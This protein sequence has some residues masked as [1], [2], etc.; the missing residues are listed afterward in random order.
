[1]K[2]II[3]ILILLVVTVSIVAA[4]VPVPVKPQSKP[5]VLT[6]GVAHLGNGRVIENSIIAFDK[7][8]IT[9]VADANAGPVDISRYEEIKIS[10]KHVYPGFILPNS[11]LGLIEV[12]SVRAM[13]DYNERGQLNPN[14][15]ALVAY[16]TDSEM[17]A[18]MR[19]NGVLLAETVPTGGLISGTSSLMEMEGWD[20]E[21]AVHTA[22]IGIHLN[23]PGLTR[24]EFDFTTFTSRQVPNKEYENLV[25][26]LSRFFTDA[27]AYGKLATKDLNL[28]MES[29]QGL[30]NGTRSLFIHAEKPKEI[31]ESVR[32]A[33][34]YGVQRMVVVG[35]SGSYPVADFLKENNIPVI[36]PPTHSVPN[37]VDED[38]DLP[39]RLP[40]LLSRAGIT[41]SLSHEGM[42]SNARNLAFYAGTAVAYGVEKEEALKMITSN[43]ARILGVDGRVG[44]LETGKDATLFICAGDVFDYRTSIL[45]H[46]FIRGK[47][48]PLPNKQEELFDRYSRKYGHK[49]EPMVAQD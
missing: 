36:L 27:E 37:T 46:A 9:L 8:K 5:V 11:Q 43:S 35:G 49:K 44:T 38:I 13:N 45:S 33:K 4:Q 25:V 48:V 7:G 10:G 32:F 16:N 47:L 30:F 17:I 19:F 34:R 22:D 39:Y 40:F 24:S 31:V 2:K 20:W 26:T 1:M 21:D 3:Y 23:W 15:R 41:V 29:M 28:K 6:G 14:V 18:T 12:G 42:A